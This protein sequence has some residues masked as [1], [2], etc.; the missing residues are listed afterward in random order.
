M[1]AVREG[2]QAGEVMRALDDIAV[3]Q[4]AADGRRQEQADRQQQAASI[5]R[6]AVVQ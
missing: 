4:I 6:S 5:S 3:R 2:V 1:N